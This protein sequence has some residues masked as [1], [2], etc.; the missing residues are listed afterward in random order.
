MS[1]WQK[2]CKSVGR[3]SVLGAEHDPDWAPSVN[4]DVPGQCQT[5]RKRKRCQSHSPS[6][7]RMSSVSCQTDVVNDVMVIDVGVQCDLDH[8]LKSAHTGAL[9]FLIFSNL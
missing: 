8:S 3:P 1:K 4:L 2:R 9:L 5:D 6:S 7:T